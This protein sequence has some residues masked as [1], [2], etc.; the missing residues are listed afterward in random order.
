MEE[1]Q[2]KLDALEKRLKIQNFNLDYS[3]FRSGPAHR[4]GIAA[5]EAEIREVEEQIRA[6]ASK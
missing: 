4:R 6:E 1:L 2:A 3:S 5:T